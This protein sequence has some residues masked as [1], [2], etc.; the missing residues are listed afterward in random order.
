[1]GQKYVTVTV[2]KYKGFLGKTSYTW[3]DNIKLDL[4]KLIYGGVEQIYRYS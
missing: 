3:E 1:M 4:K 2:E